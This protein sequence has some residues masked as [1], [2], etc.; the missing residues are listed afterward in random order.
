MSV[1]KKVKMWT[2]ISGSLLG[3]IV[4]GCSYLSKYP[5][6]NMLEEITEDLIEKETGIDIDLSPFS[7]ES[8][9]E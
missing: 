8:T 2:A 7:P 6:D 5:Q 4:A 9:K 1:S 3:A